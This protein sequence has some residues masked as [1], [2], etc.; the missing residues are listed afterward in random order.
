MNC[1]GSLAAHRLPLRRTPVVDEALAM[2]A[3]ATP[4]AVTPG[5]DASAT[6]AAFSSLAVGRRRS[7]R[8]MTSIAHLLTSLRTQQETTLRPAIYEAAPVLDNTRQTGADGR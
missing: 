7:V 6:T 8:V 1:N 5:A 4:R 3:A 2:Q